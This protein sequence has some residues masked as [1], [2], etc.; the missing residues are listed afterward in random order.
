MTEAF[1]QTIAPSQQ[2]F[3]L[4]HDALQNLLFGFFAFGKQMV[5]LH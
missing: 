2:V 3:G 1:H 4:G 5:L